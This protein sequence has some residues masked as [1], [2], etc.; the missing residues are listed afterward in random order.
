MVLELPWP[1]KRKFCTFEK[2]IFF[3][4]EKS[5]FKVFGGFSLT[6]LKLFFRKARQ[7]AQ[8]YFN[9]TLGLRT[10]LKNG[11]GATLNSKTNVLSVLKYILQFFSSALEAKLKPFFRKVRQIVQ[12]FLN[13]NIGIRSS[14]ENG[15]GA[16]SSPKTNNV[17]VSKQNFPVFCNFLSD[18]IENLFCKS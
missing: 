7:S 16:I 13:Q 14:L 11:F 18:K 3:F 8:N 5:I 10:F 9:Q 6:K 2:S 4:F 12:N 1:Q 15:F 17:R